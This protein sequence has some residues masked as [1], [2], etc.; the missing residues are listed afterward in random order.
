MKGANGRNREKKMAE[1]VNSSSQNRAELWRVLPLETPFAVHVF[2][3]YYCDFRCC[4]CI[5]S[6][7]AEEFASLN[8]K[9]QMMGINTFK[10]AV[11]G[12]TNFKSRL[13]LLNFAGHGEPLL[14]P[15][16]PEMIAYAKDKKITDKIELVTNAHTLTETKSRELVNAGLDSIRISIQGMSAEKY[17]Q[18]SSVDVD[19]NRLIEQIGYFYNHKGKCS[20]YI[21]IIDHAL[22]GIEEEKRFHETF[23]GICDR[24]AVEHMVPTAAGVDYNELDTNYGQTQQG[25]AAQSVKTCPWPFYMM[26][27]EPNGDVRTCC[28]TTFPLVLGNANEDSLSEMWKGDSLKAFWLMQLQDSRFLHPVCRSCK[29]PDYGLQP[30]DNIDNYKQE[31]LER[32]IKI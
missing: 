3:S 29:N 14:N 26:A 28:S 11:D 30:G 7:T 25:Y 18:V 13:K 20:V 19:F 12:I 32:I 22:E 2:P 31:V 4:Y 10:H 8:L 15:N 1:I 16:L 5:Q 24:I 21:K 9:K 23:G 27:V 6:L 17:R